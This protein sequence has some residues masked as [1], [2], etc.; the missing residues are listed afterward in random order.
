M[1]LSAAL[2]LSDM[3]NSLQRD[4]G[5]PADKANG[6][7]KYRANRARPL[8]AWKL[9]VL[10]MRGRHRDGEGG[11]IAAMRKAEDFD[12]EALTANV[13]DTEVGATKLDRVVCRR[14][15]RAVEDKLL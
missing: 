15:P 4:I 14:L 3:K 12:K 10:A 11:M 1:F 6:S 7:Y 13:H 2:F 9:E 5:W 8:L